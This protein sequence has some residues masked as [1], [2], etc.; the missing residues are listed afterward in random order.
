M[1]WSVAGSAGKLDV[2]WYG[3][4]YY[5]GTNPP[6]N[7]PASAQW[8]VYFAQNLRATTVGSA[9]TQVKASAVVHTGGVCESGVTCTGNR[10]LY[11]DFG[12]AANPK[13]GL[14]SIVYTDD[15]YAQTGGHQPNC[16]SA[17]NSTINCNHTGIAT[18]TSGTGIK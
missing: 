18:Q 17:D 12:I 7:Y 6:D 9:F 11:D 16:T 3:T 13:T 2:V 1:P 10:D 8:Y 4:S 5:E 14:A 15:Q